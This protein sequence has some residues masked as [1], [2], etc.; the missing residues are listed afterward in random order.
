MALLDAMMMMMRPGAHRRPGPT[1]L[2][3][4]RVLTLDLFHQR[5][6]I[7]ASPI[8]LQTHV[9]CDACV[10]HVQVYSGMLASSTTTFMI[11]TLFKLLRTSMHL[12]HSAIWL[13]SMFVLLTTLY[14]F[15][16]AAQQHS[17]GE[18]LGGVQLGIAV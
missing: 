1:L 7:I 15:M 5:L 17:V 13:T 14:P 3:Q 12:Q 11:V 18:M 2:L 6:Q 8:F 4:H 10:S 9:D 16:S